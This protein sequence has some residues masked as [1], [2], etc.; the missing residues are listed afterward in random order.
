MATEV[1]IREATVRDIP[2]LAGLLADLFALESDFSPDTDRQQKGLA[3]LLSAP[4]ARIFVAE[5]DQCAIGMCTVQVV[6]STAEGGRVGLVEDVIVKSA[7]RGRGVGRALLAALEAWAHGEGLR[8]LQ[9]LA[10][11]DNHPAHGFY[12]K[13]G[14]T[15]T[16]LRAWRRRI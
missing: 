16:R 1:S 14:W 13:N 4:A 3:A 5:V 12:R 8:R 7:W 15:E 9:L 10:D 2:A 11:M 6:I